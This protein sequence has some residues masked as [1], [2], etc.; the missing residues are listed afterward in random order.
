LYERSKDYEKAAGLYAEA[1]Q[2]G[3]NKALIR[4]AH[5]NAHGLGM[6]K[7]KKKADGLLIQAAAQG[8][9]WAQLRL[10]QVYER[11]NRKAGIVQD[12]AMAVQLYSAAAA[13]GNRNA[14]YR[15]G[16]IYKTGAGT[17]VAADPHKALAYFKQGAL[18]GYAPAQ[19]EMGQMREMAQG[20]AGSPVAAYYWYSMAQ[21]RGH[22]LAS[23]RLLS[24]RSK[25][26]ADDVKKAEG[27][28]RQHD[29]QRGAAVSQ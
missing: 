29:L 27:L 6:A 10:G 9:Q 26:T 13:Q 15:L 11:G 24:L 28:L 25:M 2:K 23:E 20:V 17:T 3:D 4:L 19:Y 21:R 16:R 14:A 18:A 7:D 1:I 12:P 8:G 5:L 22:E